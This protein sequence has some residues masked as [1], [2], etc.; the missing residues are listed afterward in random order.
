MLFRRDVLGRIQQG[1]VTLAFRR[2]RK[3]PPP[4]GSTIKTAIGVLS[5][6]RIQEIK[7]SEVSEEDARRSGAVSREELLRSLGGDGVLLRMELRLAGDDP[8]VALR[9]RGLEDADEASALL[10]RLEKRDA[11][12]SGPP[13]RELLCIIRENPGVAAR[14]L[15]RRT[16]LETMQ[17][18]R[19]VRGLKELGLTESLETGYRLSPRGRDA[20]RLLERR[21]A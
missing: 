11:R 21:E 20:L 19:R 5:L 1:E 17:L 7:E 8:R 12:G 2:W 15:A 6:D 10:E 9:A 14:E 3:K 13:T 4:D 18:K 16:S